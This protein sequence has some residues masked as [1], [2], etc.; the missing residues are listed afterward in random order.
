MQNLPMGENSVQG[1][2]K[3]TFSII[4]YGTVAFK[5]SELQSV[6]HLFVGNLS[7]NQLKNSTQLSKTKNIV[8][9]FVS[10][11]QIAQKFQKKY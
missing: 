9:V 10:Q 2:L 5:E 4:N 3:I 7:E 8:S 6:R 11:Y 1:K